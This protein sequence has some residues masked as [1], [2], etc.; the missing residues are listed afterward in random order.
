MS[1]ISVIEGYRE[2]LVALHRKRKISYIARESGIERG[3]L[4]RFV[5]NRGNSYERFIDGLITLEKK[6]LL[7]LPEGIVRL[8]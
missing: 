7:K 3:A 4:W 8:R 6:G 2:Q 5:T 1:E